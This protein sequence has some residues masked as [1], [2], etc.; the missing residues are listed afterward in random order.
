MCSLSLPLSL[1]ATTLTV[2]IRH[3]FQSQWQQKED[4]AK[5]LKISY[6][7]HVLATRSS[8]HPDIHEWIYC[9]CKHIKVQ[10]PSSSSFAI[11]I[12]LEDEIKCRASGSAYKR[13]E[14]K[15]FLLGSLF[16]IWVSTSEH[17]AH[18]SQVKVI[19]GLLIRKWPQNKDK[20]SP[21]PG[22]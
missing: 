16:T 4:N 7:R 10:R 15:G 2:R 5:H 21:F 6:L 9:N 17:I 1:C 20:L 12:P 11:C 18:N 14:T 3:F 8:R 13:K 22:R 19:Y